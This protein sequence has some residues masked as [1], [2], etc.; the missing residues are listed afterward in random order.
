METI[1]FVLVICVALVAV[2]AYFAAKADKA[3]TELTAEKQRADRLASSHEEVSDKLEGVTP[4]WIPNPQ[5]HHRA[6]KKYL[7]VGT[8]QGVG[9]F[10]DSAIAE[11]VERH[12][13]LFEE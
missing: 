4:R 11:A 5:P 8:P 13:R 9:L 6:D 2:T 1:Y 10:T 3:K 7:R 12:K